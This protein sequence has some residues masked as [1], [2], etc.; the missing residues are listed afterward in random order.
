MH[1][2]IPSFSVAP[3]TDPSARLGC[4]QW[5]HVDGRLSNLTVASAAS[6]LTDFDRMTRLCTVDF[7]VP[8]IA[9]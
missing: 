2:L 7:A 6:P 4:L 8:C 9:P 1:V 3:H 5:L